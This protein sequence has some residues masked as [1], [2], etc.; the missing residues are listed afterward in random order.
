MKVQIRTKIE[1]T[2][3]PQ[4]PS[5]YIEAGET[6]YSVASLEEKIRALQ[7]AK[8]WLVRELKK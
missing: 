2:C 1:S 7:I 5:V 4:K 3:S 8:L 6:I